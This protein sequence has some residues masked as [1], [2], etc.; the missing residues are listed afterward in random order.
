MQVYVVELSLDIFCSL[1]FR[2]F[3]C[4]VCRFFP[5]NRVFLIFETLNEQKLQNVKRSGI[6][7][8]VDDAKNLKNR[9]NMI[10]FLYKQCRA[11][12]K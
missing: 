4:R 10:V 8:F 1:S 12:P 5:I 6:Q 7:S 2:L 3:S 9:C 11:I